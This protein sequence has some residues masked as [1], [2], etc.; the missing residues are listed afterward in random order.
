MLGDLEHAVKIISDFHFRILPV[1]AEQSSS[2]HH[3]KTPNKA[4]STLTANGE[5]R[6]GHVTV[7]KRFGSWIDPF[8]MSGIQKCALSDLFV[9][10]VEVHNA[11]DFFQ[12]LPIDSL[13][14]PCFSVVFTQGCAHARWH[15]K[16]TQLPH[17]TRLL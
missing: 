4:S 5:P 9:L 3:E 7:K 13:L 14:I 15:C 17:I 11:S 6:I 12:K 1:G 2:C 8:E 10:E 16:F